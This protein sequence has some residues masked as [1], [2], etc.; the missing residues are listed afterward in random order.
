MRP[1]GKPGQQTLDEAR[2][3]EAR[4]LLRTALGK[5]PTRREQT[6]RNGEANLLSSTMQWSDDYSYPIPANR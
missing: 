3:P 6:E 2:L 4:M 1:K 5:G